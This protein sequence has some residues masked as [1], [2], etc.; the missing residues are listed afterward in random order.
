MYF[1]CIFETFFP[2]KAATNT[3]TFKQFS[4]LLSS[5]EIKYFVCENIYTTLDLSISFFFVPEL[6][7]EQLGFK[8]SFYS[9]TSIGTMKV[10]RK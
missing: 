1:L 4:V 7:K 5:Q 8:L 3:G 9:K 6:K 10:Y 2:Q